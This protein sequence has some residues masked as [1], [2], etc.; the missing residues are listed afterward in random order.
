MA[1]VV[2]ACLLAEIRFG[3][4]R[5]PFVVWEMVSGIIFDPHVLALARAEGLLDWL[6]SPGV[7]LL[8][9]MIAVALRS[10]PVRSANIQGAR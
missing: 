5:V 9:P 2:A 3:I 7:V 1:I 6:G 8:F 4:F 10:R